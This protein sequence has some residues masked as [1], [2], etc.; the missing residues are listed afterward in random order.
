MQGLCFRFAIFGKTAYFFEIMFRF[1]AVGQGYAASQ[2]YGIPEHQNEIMSD[3]KIKPVLEKF[4]ANVKQV[5]L[6]DSIGASLTAVLLVI[7]LG[8]FNV[9]VGMPEKTLYLLLLAATLLAIYSFSCYRFLSTK[10]K[11]YLKAII[12]ANIVYSCLT[13]GFVILHYPKLSVFGV[14]YFVGEMFLIGGVIFLEITTLSKLK[15]RVNGKMR[16]PVIVETLV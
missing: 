1:F 3:S 9:Y 4:T 8:S 10:S 13:I 5:F 15:L 6:L 7:M 11:P 2:P 12:I 14:I 16:G